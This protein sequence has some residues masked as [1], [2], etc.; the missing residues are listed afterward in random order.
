MLHMLSS[1]DDD[2]DDGSST[3]TSSSLF[4]GRSIDGR[5]VDHTELEARHR[6]KSGRGVGGERGREKGGM[7]RTD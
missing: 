2:N 4:T 6:Q 1:D 3:S 5:S 7:V